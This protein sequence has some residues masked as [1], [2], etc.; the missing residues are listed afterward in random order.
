[1]SHAELKQ[2]AVESIRDKIRQIEKKLQGMVTGVVRHQISSKQVDYDSSCD[3]EE[4]VWKEIAAQAGWGI[5][6][7][8]SNNTWL[9]LVEV[10]AEQLLK[11]TILGEGCNHLSALV[12]EIKAKYTSKQEELGKFTKAEE[13]CQEIIRGL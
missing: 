10:G 13:N 1:M 9:P 12:A 7:K 8:S 4:L 2:R 3:V 11:V 5:Y 6:Y